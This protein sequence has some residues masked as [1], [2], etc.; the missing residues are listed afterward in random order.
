MSEGGRAPCSVVG[1]SI[2]PIGGN[3]REL[4]REKA[5]KKQ[6]ASGKGKPKVRVQRGVECV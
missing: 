4:A 5:A 3:Q 6:G 2:A 1:S